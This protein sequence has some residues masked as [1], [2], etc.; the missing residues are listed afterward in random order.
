MKRLHEITDNYRE[1]HQQEFEDIDD[2]ENDA[3]EDEDH[4][5]L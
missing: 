1:E 3:T 4:D 5:N 2:I